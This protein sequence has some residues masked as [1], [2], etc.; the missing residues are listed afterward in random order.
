ME[1]SA[2]YR[3]DLMMRQHKPNNSKKK[4]ENSDD[5][6]NRWHQNS[7]H[8][9]NASVKSIGEVKV[10]VITGRFNRDR[11]SKA[12]RCQVEFSHKIVTLFGTKAKS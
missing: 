2:Q 5:N 3:Q 8:F 7:K 1:K 12:T 4:H 9:K 10:E 11:N 6:N